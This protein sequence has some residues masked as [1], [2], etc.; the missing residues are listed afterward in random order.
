MQ[1]QAVSNTVDN[2]GHLFYREEYKVDHRVIPTNVQ[3]NVLIIKVNKYLPRKKT[4]YLPNTK[5]IYK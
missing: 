2:V 3:V 1:C 4:Q 5:L